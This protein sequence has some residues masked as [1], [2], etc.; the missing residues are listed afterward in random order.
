M[1]HGDPL[2]NPMITLCCHQDDIMSFQPAV[3]EK[4]I[5]Y[6][7][8]CVCVTD[9]LFF[10]MQLT[11]FSVCHTEVN[12]NIRI[13]FSK[14]HEKSICPLP[15]FFFCGIFVTLTCFRSEK[16]SNIRQRY[17]SCDWLVTCTG[18]VLPYDIWDI[19]QSSLTLIRISWRERM[20]GWT[21]IPRINAKCTKVLRDKSYS[22]L[23]GPM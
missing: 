6:I 23:P 3:N 14:Q 1:A 4:D 20:H 17:Q 13:P 18:C 9:V 19:L 21:K 2:L 22:N 8:V 11:I 16:K 12:K 10:I 15:D 5:L 7:C